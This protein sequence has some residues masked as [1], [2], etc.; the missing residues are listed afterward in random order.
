MAINLY[1]KYTEAALIEIK[2]R[3][4]LITLEQNLMGLSL[5]KMNLKNCVLE[6]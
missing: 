3:K 2:E 4:L 6:R 1:G 5:I